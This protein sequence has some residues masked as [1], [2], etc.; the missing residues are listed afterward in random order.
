MA[1][2]S[3][4]SISLLVCVFA[5]LTLSGVLPHSQTPAQAAAAAYPIQLIPDQLA[6][7]G[8]VA[9]RDNTVGLCPGKWFDGTPAGTIML[10]I[11]PTSCSP[12]DWDGG[13]ATAQ[14]L[15]PNVHA[16]TLLALTLAWTNLDGKGL[17]SPDRNRSGSIRL[18]GRELWGKRTTEL[19][20]YNDYYA[21]ERGPI[22]ITVVL[23][24]TAVHTLE[25]RV[26]ARTAWDLSQIEITAYPF[27]QT[28]RGVGYSPYRDCQ[29]PGGALQ[30]SEQDITED[31]LRLVHASNAI[32]IYSATGANRLV[33]K[34]ANQIGLPIY[35]GAWIDQDLA[36]DQTEVDALARLAHTTTLAGALVG[37]E[38]F[39][40]HHAQ[41]PQDMAY[42][43]QQVMKV[44]QALADTRIPLGT[45]E[46]DSFMFSW[47]NDTTAQ[48][49]PEYKP[50]VQQLDFVMVHIYP[51]WMQRS[52]EGAAELTV[53][54]Y[55]AMQ[56][57][58]ARE[59]LNQ[60][61]IIGE[62]GWSSE[63]QLVGAAAP[64]LVNQRRY[65]IEFL[66]LAE[67]EKIDYLYFEAF[68]ELWKAGEGAAGR[69]WGFGYSDRTAKHN[70]FG[71]L[72]PSALLSESQAEMLVMRSQTQPKQS[73]AAMTS[74]SSIG[75]LFP[76]RAYL[77][78][79]SLLSVPFPVYQEWPA[80]AG[81]FVPSGVMGDPNSASVFEC[82]RTDPHGGD[83]AARAM[84]VPTGPK[85]WGGV[86]WQYPENNWGMDSNGKALR[87]ANKLT[88][89]AR[90]A[91]GGEKVEFFVGGI[92]TTQTTYPDS[93][94]PS[95]STG[96]IAL[97]NTWQEY[98]IN[99]TG[100]D[101]SRVNGGF[102]WSANQ[103]ANQ[104]GA[105]FFLDD[106]AFQY[107]SELA[108][109]SPHGPIVPVYSDAAAPN[110]HYAPSLRTGDGENERLMSLTECWS[111]NPHS[112]QT[113]I[114]ISYNASQR[115]WAGTYWVHPAENIGDLP[116]GF[117][118]TDANR[119]TFWAR[120][121]TPN[122]RV[123]FLLGGV[124]YDTDFSGTA[125]CTKKLYDYADSLCPPIVQEEILSTAWQKYTIDL[126]Q[127]PK[128]DLSRVIG[129]FGWISNQPLTF[130]LDD[131]QYEFD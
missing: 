62:A 113:S 54:R 10:G 99:L 101:L 6:L 84:F 122:A 123:K 50:I 87:W 59:H 34:L 32:R 31:L 11:D 24:Q 13:S 89:W 105:I 75:Q 2:R 83:M 125:D 48:L 49:K 7:S 66:R 61:L 67:Q 93:V 94:R 97:E 60:R 107:D 120:S 71:V 121:D 8:D 96:F 69:H 103:C 112:G 102:G 9:T 116:G 40:R 55:R 45:A 25:F 16:P 29:A 19:G 35:V 73:S 42:L 110:N 76:A 128:R 21:A 106:I 14:V 1:H 5:T 77:P 15:L 92:G 52:I 79:M 17:H 70:F 28:I 104:Q 20:T 57:A 44:K 56:A 100:Q 88:F 58:L 129:G 26:P 78:L 53:K 98:T 68:D 108:P 47:T 39:W 33:P 63:G 80:D 23:T 126:H 81:H 91:K 109:P 131:I 117:D 3:S 36:K 130:Y 65:M 30:P 43:L 111:E 95:V 72:L 22:R 85:G 38:Y 18:D 118:L 12:S 37:S 46:I 74:S 82:D 114:K 51:F 124:G 41:P 119:L 64:S 86:Y 127:L 4:R 90:G 115:G 27:P